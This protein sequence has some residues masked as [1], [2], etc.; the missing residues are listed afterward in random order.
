MDGS[1]KEPATAV[2][3]GAL[4]C[5]AKLM[6][7]FYYNQADLEAA[8]VCS[9]DLVGSPLTTVRLKARSMTKS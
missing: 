3:A 5:L 1:K 7:C 2:S 4:M 9:E 8:E 6:S